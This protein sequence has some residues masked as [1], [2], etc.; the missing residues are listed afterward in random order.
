MSILSATMSHSYSS[1]P[2][3]TGFLG[4]LIVFLLFVAGMVG[5]MALINVHQV[6]LSPLWMTIFAIMAVGLAAGA[7]SRLFFYKWPGFVR[8]FLMLLVLLPALFVLGIL[9]NWQIGI[10]PLNPWF[11]GDIDPDELVQLGGALLVACI[12]LEAWWKP[13]SRIND[14]VMP[15]VRRSTRSAYREPSPMAYP[16]Q[17]PQRPAALQVRSPENLTY[18]AKGRSRLKFAKANTKTRSRGSH[19]EKLVL[20]HTPQPTRSRRKRLFNRKPQLQISMYE[21]HKCPF[22]LEEVKRNDSRG[23]KKCPVCNTL[24]HADCWA[25]TGFCQVPHLNT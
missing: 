21:E 16:V 20:A 5:L 13:T 25:I 15:E 9:T 18:Q 23:V 17:M 19:A 10:G 14:D 1:A 3:R 12:A 4:K 24:H 8:F 2:R 7:G 6:N 11:V 22:C